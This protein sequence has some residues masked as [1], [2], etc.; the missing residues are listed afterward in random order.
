MSTKKPPS[1]S[2][3]KK[4]RRKRPIF[5]DEFIQWHL[6]TSKHDKCPWCGFENIG[7]LGKR[8]RTCMNNSC[9]LMISRDA[10]ST[11]FF[12]EKIEGEVA[13]DY[14]EPNFTVVRLDSGRSL[15]VAQKESRD[16]RAMLKVNHG[17]EDFVIFWHPDG[18]GPEDEDGNPAMAIGSPYWHWILTRI[19]Y[20]DGCPYWWPAEPLNPLEVLAR[21]GTDDPVYFAQGMLTT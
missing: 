15:G 6:D 2:A 12:N 19:Q 13:I 1:A 18:H 20:G 16:K 9:N 10:P 4:K 14:G 3:L 8:R 17:G 5:S 21:A 7:Y 11:E